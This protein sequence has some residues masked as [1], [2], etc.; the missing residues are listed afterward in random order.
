M[1]KTLIAMLVILMSCSDT[2]LVENWKNPDIVLFHANKVLIV[3]MTQNENPRVD[4]ETRLKKEFDKRDVEAMRS[5]DLFDVRFTDSKRTEEELDDMEQSLLEKDF[6]AILLTKITGSENRQSFRKS[7]AQWSNFKGRFRD[8]YLRNQEI[9]YN[10]DYY[11][12]LTVYNAETSL[13]CICEGKERSLIW[14][15]SIDIMDPGNIDKTV[16]EYVKLVVAAMEEQDLVFHT[17]A[18]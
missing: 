17:D 18:I 2:S 13:Y 15:G 5:I 8:D 10:P 14:R 11:D 7:V 3:G 6:D 1:K 4:F 9:Y 16:K 12:D